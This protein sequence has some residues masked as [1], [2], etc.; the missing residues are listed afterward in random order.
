MSFEREIWLFVVVPDKMVLGCGTDDISYRT[1]VA[2]Q[3]EQMFGCFT[4]GFRSQCPDSYNPQLARMLGEINVVE[5]VHSRAGRKCRNKHLGMF[6]CDP[7]THSLP[8][9][10]KGSGQDS[11]DILPT[12]FPIDRIQKHIVA[13][14]GQ[15]APGAQLRH[16]LENTDTQMPCAFGDTI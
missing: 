6:I 12:Q 15:A 5:R 16:C 14:Q 9:F 2:P 8:T 7:R 11:T 1:K 4:Q 3:G 10:M 13:H